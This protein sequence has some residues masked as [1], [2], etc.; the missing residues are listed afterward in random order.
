MNSNWLS[1]AINY[2]RKVKLGGVFDDQTVFLNLKRFFD[3]FKTVCNFNGEWLEPL[4]FADDNVFLNV[5]NEIESS[6]EFVDYV[7]KDRGRKFVMYHPV[8]PPYVT[9]PLVYIMN[10]PTIAH[11]YENKRYFRDEFADLINLPD[12][13]IKRLDEI[14]DETFDELSA[15]WD[16][17]VLQDVE[18]SGFKG[19]F[20]ASTREEFYA[21][22]E[23][24]KTVSFSG[25]IVISEF[26]HGESCSIQVCITKYGVFA[27]G[28]QRQIVNSEYLCN[29]EQTDSTKWCGG[30][31]GGI[32][33]DIETHRAR[34][35]ATVIGS[36]LAS[37]G[38]RGIFGID[39]II[40]PEHEVFAIEINARIT[41]FSHVIS[42]M[43]FAKEKIPFMLLHTLELGNIPYEVNDAEDLPQPSS[44]DQTYSYLILINKNNHGL[45][46]KRDIKSGVY[47][48]KG[49]SV[50]YL[51]P[52]FSVIDLN[53]ENE[54]IILSKF[55]R[56]GDV[57]G[58]G[59]RI[60]KI[61]LKG[62]AIDEATHDLDENAQQI[63]ARVC[64]GLDIKF[65][66]EK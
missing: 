2:N 8:S 1:D 59:K 40:T 6:K 4:G 47:K 58:R 39:L 18:L 12:H 32:F 54:I 23:K 62:T 38:Y 14:D 35:I 16:K 52:S 33:P 22:I 3:D 42:D 36:E 56:T 28:I 10:S 51:R 15:T 66:G 27:G 37:H 60:L 7:K 9:N 26:V 31:I 34:E 44:L 24:L 57:V 17:M 43:Q 48:I 45:V 65:D 55:A 63:V 19:T 25:T 64:K 53:D 46:L 30:E 50:E 13:V 49:D 20:F 29:K 41:G 61:L 11:A 21:A 5:D